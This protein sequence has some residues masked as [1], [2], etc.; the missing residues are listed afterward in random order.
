MDIE[1]LCSEHM[2]PGPSTHLRVM[3]LHVSVE[4]Q[5]CGPKSE[6]SRQ[7]ALSVQKMDNVDWL[8]LLEEFWCLEHTRQI[9]PG[10]NL[11]LENKQVGQYDLFLAFLNNTSKNW[12]SFCPFSLFSKKGGLFFARSGSMIFMRA[13]GTPSARVRMGRTSWWSDIAVVGHRGV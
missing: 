2:R 11:A 12:L 6:K 4:Y 13:L 10:L 9:A 5:N 1:I 7:K 3:T 8:S